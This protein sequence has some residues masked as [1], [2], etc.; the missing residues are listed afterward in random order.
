MSSF[1]ATHGAPNAPPTYY[2]QRESLQGR[3]YRQPPASSYSYQH[4]LVLN[5][6]ADILTQRYPSLPDPSVNMNAD[7]PPPTPSG[8]ATSSINSLR[9]G[10]NQ[11]SLVRTA[12]LLNE[13]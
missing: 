11:V 13:F 10:Q 4:G 5:Q 6:A 7:E 2:V 3:A 8:S 1:E 12:L 9:R